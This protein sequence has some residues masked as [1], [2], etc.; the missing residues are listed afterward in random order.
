M[1]INL[2]E[3]H[4]TRDFE[5]SLSTEGTT[6]SYVVTGTTDEQAV[7]DH[8]VAN[9]PVTIGNLSRNSIKAKFGGGG[10]WTVD[11]GYGTND[12]NSAVGE[13]PGTPPSPES[14]APGVPAGLDHPLDSSYEM[15]TTGQTVHITQALSTTWRATTT[16][17]NDG[18]DEQL[19]IGL[20]ADKVEGCDIYAGTF[21]FSRTVARAHVTM[22]YINAALYGLVGRTNDDTFY[23]FAAGEVLYLG[24]TGTFTQQNGW[25]LTHKFACSPNETAV[26]IGG[27]ITLPTKGGWQFVWVRYAPKRVGNLVLPVPEVAY[28]QRVYKTGDFSLL[29]IGV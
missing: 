8:V 20:T 3:H 10:F 14:P 12:A 28:C 11:V 9:T 26:V 19:A 17:N 2:Y 7:F 21:T 4:N 16:G 29:E 1:A 5:V 13:T 22:G 23:T 27:G 18:P 15:E 6:R 24:C 25:S